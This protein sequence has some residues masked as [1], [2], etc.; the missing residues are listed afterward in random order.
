MLK[1]LVKHNGLTA[2]PRWGVKV[3]SLERYGVKCKF[4][5]VQSRSP[6]LSHPLVTEGRG[7]MEPLKKPPF[8]PEV[9][10]EICTIYVWT[11]KKHNSAKNI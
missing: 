9:C 1:V 8:P 4:C 7:S 6:V 10:T 2:D 11:I 3:F 5:N